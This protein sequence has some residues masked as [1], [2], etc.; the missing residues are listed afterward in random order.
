M[1][2]FLNSAILI[3]LAAVS[4]PIL[5]HLF[6]R[7]KIKIIKFSSLRFLK[8]LQKQKIRRLKIRQ[9]LLLI[10]RAL[11][12]L[13]LVFAF[14]RPAL[15]RS[16]S[17]SLET[18][19]QL[20][21][22]IILDNTLSMGR[23]MEGRRLLDRA[24]EK[25]QQVVTMLR[26]GDE[27]YILY[28]QDP[29][30]FPHEGPRYNLESVQELIENTEL[31][32]STTDYITALNLAD[33]I[34]N[35]SSNINKEV[36]L[37]GDLQ[38]NGL[39]LAARNNDSNLLAEQVNLYVLP[40]VNSTE[41]NLAI[42]NV[43]LGNQI[44][45]KGKVV[46]I[47]TVIK[48]SSQNAVKNKLVHL[49]VNGKR[50][51]QNAVNLAPESSTSVI[52]R[53]VPDRTGLQSGFVLLEDDDLVEDNR[54]FFTFNIPEEIPV[55][56]VGSQENDTYFINLA[57]SPDKESTSF[58]KLKQILD[59]DLLQQNLG[60]FEII[61]LSNVTK[62]DRI[63]SGK[64]QS[65]VAQGGGLMIFLGADVDLRNYNENL[66]KKLNLP[67]L[68]EAITSQ[69]KDQFLSLGKIDFSHPIFNGVFEDEKNVVS[70]LFRFAVNLK[71]NVQMD[72]IIEFSNGATFLFESQFQQG[73]IMYITSGISNDWSDLALRGIFVPLVNRSVSYMAGAT[74]KDQDE[75]YI[76][77]EITFY[78][79]SQA[80]NPNLSMEKPD[81]IQVKIKPEVSKGKYFMRFTETDLPGIYNLYNNK[82]SLAQWAVNYNPV[83]SEHAVFNIDDLKEIVAT[84]QVTV[85]DNTGL[86]S[87]KL[88]ESRFGRELWKYFAAFALILLLTEMLLFREKG[89]VTKEKVA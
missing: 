4:I 82:E 51:G 55:L 19:A 62:L 17:S 86:I 41:E 61:I 12:I 68:T 23:E 38:T 71:A 39:S 26:P 89:E 18:G 1:F 81:N 36:Y 11:L 34:M 58:I 54:R 76:S 64:I 9:I 37:I 27:V 33:N 31:S 7:Q 52:F 87:E 21:A 49:F 22:V 60:A 77:E 47:V 69:E 46:E 78:P 48:N 50:V 28:P 66:H 84:D 72:K 13:S 56:L 63:E 43:K 73:R 29:P 67:L 8:E 79:E 30:I 85:I 2:T 25:A 35:N 57:L 83:E 40:V 65:F 16:R 70:P 75:F 10:L 5:I 42:Y 44:L 14:S 59:K 53:M 20:T 6:T 88:N 15:K 32:Y 45:E 80:F 24:K 74:A 3:G